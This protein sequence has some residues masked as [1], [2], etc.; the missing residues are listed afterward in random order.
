MG[1]VGH[2]ARLM[3]P[4]FVKPYVKSNKNDANHSEAICEAVT[5]PSMRFVPQKSVEQQGLSVSIHALGRRA[6]VIQISRDLKPL[7]S[8]HAVAL[9]VYRFAESDF[10]REAVSP[11]NFTNGTLLVS[12]SL[13]P[14]RDALRH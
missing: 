1:G 3:A 8:I 6:T 2:A 10:P 13:G 4:Q 11:R 9:A 12:C 5:R 14:H 7:V